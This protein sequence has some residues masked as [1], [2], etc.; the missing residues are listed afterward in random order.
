METLEK[1]VELF[2][3]KGFHATSMQDLVSHLGIN[4]ASL[5]GTY[6]DKHGL[7]KKAIKAYTKSNG[8][9]LKN[10][11]EK[12]EDQ[13]TGLRKMFGFISQTPEAF[14]ASPGCFVVNT[15]VEMLPNEPEYAPLL[16]QCKEEVLTI[17]GQFIARTAPSN[18]PM[19]PEQIDRKAYLIYTFQNGLQVLAKSENNPQR[20]Q[21]LIDDFF[22]GL[23]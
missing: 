11:L 2:W 5:Y 10:L 9:I 6:G 17:L 13:I 18:D 12:E 3:N 20:I 15:A 8:E 14:S 4:R 19:S 7:F 16:K 22:K 1:A 21:G 23:K